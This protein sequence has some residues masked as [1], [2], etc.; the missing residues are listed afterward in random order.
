MA[1]TQRGRLDRTAL[2][3]LPIHPGLCAGC[4]HLELQG[5]RRNVFVRC[6][7]ADSDPSFPRYP[8]L[9]VRACRGW[10]RAMDERS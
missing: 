8:S 4:A 2:N 10:T 3:R 6:A 1:K 7:V 5:S 9:P